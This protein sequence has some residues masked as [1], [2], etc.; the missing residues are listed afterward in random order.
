MSLAVETTYSNWQKGCLMS[1]FI[2]FVS[3]VR[4]KLNG[5]IYWLRWFDQDEG[6]Y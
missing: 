6:I 4:P 1:L 5:W 3:L 2:T